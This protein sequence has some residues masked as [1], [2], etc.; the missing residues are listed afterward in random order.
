[1]RL[2][3]QTEVLDAGMPGTVVGI[4]IVRGEVPSVPA[5]AG[6]VATLNEPTRYWILH[7]DYSDF[8]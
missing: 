1:M 7:V 5:S 4:P 2:A 3:N 6:T 8:Y